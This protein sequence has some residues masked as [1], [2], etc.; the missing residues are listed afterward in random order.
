MKTWG[1]PQHSADGKAERIISVLLFFGISFLIAVSGLHWGGVRPEVSIWLLGLGLLFWSLLGIS[2]W[3]AWKKGRAF[4]GALDWTV[5]AFVFYAGISYLWT[6]TEYPARFE[7]MWILTYAGLFLCVRH[8]FVSRAWGQAILAVLIFTALASC[9][10]A[11]I[12]KSDPTHLIWGVPRPDY[13]VRISGTFGCPNHFADFLDLAL[14]AALM[15]AAIPRT[16]WVVRIILFYFAGMFALGVFLSISR[17]GMIALALG[18]AV[19]VYYLMRHLHLGWIWKAAGVL[20]LAG[21]FVAGIVLNDKIFKR[22][23]Q[24]PMGDIRTTLA[25]DALKIWET[26]PWVGTGMASFDYLHMRVHGPGYQTRAIYTHCDYLNTLSDY[27]L[28]GLGLA[29]LFALALFLY[30]RVQSGDRISERE[31][32]FRRMGLAALVVIL[33]HSAVDFSLHIPACAIAF[34]TL[35]GLA[36][37]RT[38]RDQRHEASRFPSSWIYLG[39]AAAALFALAWTLVPTF[40]SQRVLPPDEERI[41]SMSVADL[42]LLGER[43]L[44][45]DPGAAPQFEEIADA[46]RLHAGRFDLEI[47]KNL[48]GNL[49]DQKEM[50]AKRFLERNTL[51]DMALTYYARALRANPLDDTLLIKQAMCY[52]LKQSYGEAGILYQTALQNRPYN[53]Y[54]HY[55]VGIHFL[56]QGD[57]ITARD[58]FRTAQKYQGGRQSQAFSKEAAKLTQEIEKILKNLEQ[59]AVP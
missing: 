7:W 39:F 24:I 9:I 51:C 1:I 55:A 11:L 57:L 10:F 52:D 56:R 2:S 31:I 28:I 8:C 50:I 6:P 15:L 3:I 18:G 36:S 41:R 35:A 34:F 12:H 43:I 20:G 23:E 21:T 38:T 44:R 29:L 59:R 48:P 30:L 13:G 26:S 45:I 32:W 53:R 33:A 40:R 27:G 25:L 5:A 49:W 14:V 42:N 46:Y 4:G 17:G 47:E 54:F 58:Y 16:P 22:V 19:M 37:M